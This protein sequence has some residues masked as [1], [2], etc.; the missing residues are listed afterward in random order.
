MALES[1]KAEGTGC[2]SDPGQTPE[3]ADLSQQPSELLK[4]PA[5][6]TQEREPGAPLL[7]AVRSVK[8]LSQPPRCPR[9]AQ[10][11]QGAQ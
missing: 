7:G 2:A 8:N 3:E 4:V 9:A 11:P 6:H 10:G 5:W 1:L